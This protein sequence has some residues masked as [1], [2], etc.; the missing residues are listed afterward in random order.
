MR[1]VI[2][3]LLVI[4]G[5]AT[6]LGAVRNIPIPCFAAFIKEFDV[7]HALNAGIF[8]ILIIIHVWLNRKPLF[9]YFGKLGW[10]WIPV[11][12]GF[13]GVVWGGVVMTILVAEG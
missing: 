11:G 6:I 8:T 2:S 3:I 1:R 4:F 5:A 13:A 10:W 12:L 7:G 9:R